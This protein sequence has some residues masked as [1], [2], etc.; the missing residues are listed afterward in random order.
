MP[1]DV[2]HSCAAIIDIMAA[3]QMDA[4]LRQ[5]RGS[6]LWLI[7]ISGK[8]KLTTKPEKILIDWFCPNALP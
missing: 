7:S 5:I 2:K 1:E 8:T 6:C 3:T 4:K